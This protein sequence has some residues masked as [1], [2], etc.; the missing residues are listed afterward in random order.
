MTDHPL[1]P[2]ARHLELLATADVDL[3]ARVFQFSRLLQRNG[4]GGRVLQR[5]QSGY[6]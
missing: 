2:S 1:P 3:S 4:A 6:E 5:M